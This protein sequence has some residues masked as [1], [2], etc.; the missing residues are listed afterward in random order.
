MTDMGRQRAAVVVVGVLA[1]GAFALTRR[2]REDTMPRVSA[3]APSALQ[4]QTQ[5]P[6]ATAGAD[7]PPGD[8]RST[9]TLSARSPR[10]TPHEGCFVRPPGH[11]ESGAWCTWDGNDAEMFECATA[12]DDCERRR[13]AWSE[14]QA[15]GPRAVACAFIASAYCTDMGGGLGV[16]RCRATLAQCARFRAAFRDAS[17]CVRR[18]MF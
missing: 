12:R 2:P 15:D 3:Q 6:D 5:A 13:D 18:A 4:E 17:P 1:A 7:T 8:E 9:T 16:R 10:T 14:M 11:A